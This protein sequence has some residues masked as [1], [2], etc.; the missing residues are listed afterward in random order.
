[1]NIIY[2]MIINPKPDIILELCQYPAAILTSHLVNNPYV[3]LTAT[4]APLGA[5]RTDND[6]SLNENSDVSIG[7]CGWNTSHA[8]LQQ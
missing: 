4:R 5:V 7:I 1:M 8:F 2:R 6:I 3:H